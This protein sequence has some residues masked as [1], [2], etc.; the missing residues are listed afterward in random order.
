LFTLLILGE[1]FHVF[2]VIMY[3]YTIWD[4]EYEAPRKNDHVEPVDIFVTVAGEPLDIVEETILAIKNI[5]YPTF[6]VYILNDGYVAKKENWQEME[7]L[8]ENLGVQCIT[9]KTPGGA[10]AGNINNGM[11]NTHS[12]LIVVFDADHVPHRDFL[13]KTV[14]YFFDKKVGF[15]QSPQYYKNYNL[16]YVTKSAWEQQQLFFGPICRGKNRMNATTMCGTNMVIRR[17]AMEEV[18]GMSETSIAEDFLTGLLMHE[19]GWK[20]VYVAE[21]L[22]EGLAPEDFLSYFKQQFRWARGALDLVFP[23]NR[24]LEGNMTW[25]QRLQ[26]FSS[27]SFYF[28]GTV[29]LMN[30]L[31]PTVYFFTGIVPLVTSTMVLASIFLPY[32]FLTLYILQKSSNFNFTFR[33][34]TFSLGAFNIHLLALWSAISNKKATFSITPKKQ[35]SGNFIRLATPHILYVLLVFIGIIY[36]FIRDGATASFIANTSWGLLNIAVFIPTIYAASPRKSP[37]SSLSENIAIKKI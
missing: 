32:L 21:I 2:Q 16:N 37:I 31:I 14:P 9:R 3:M 28:S 5:D 25:R 17:Q 35:V 12:P 20:S 26:Y 11:K 23:K 18:G 7:E 8:A 36:A 4:M 10:K 27:V 29:V 34:L 13:K 6:N 19:R 33:A 22:A 1:V 24:I 15:V 30:A